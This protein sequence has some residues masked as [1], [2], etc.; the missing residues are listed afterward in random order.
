MVKSV[1]EIFNILKK[2]YKLKNFYLASGGLVDVKGVGTS[3]V[4]IVYLVSANTDYSNLD[5]IFVDYKKD[6]RPDKDRCYYISTFGGR[7]VSICAS[8]NK[9][10]MR[11]VVH[12]KAELA[13]N[14]YP[15]ITA[16]AINY[17]LDGMKTE[18]A[19]AKVLD[20][21]GDPYDAMTMN[22]TKLKKIAKEKEQKLEKI[23]KGLNTE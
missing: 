15:L 8:N 1:E 3:D 10:V 19:W 12:R 21:K 13:L 7:E 9:N 6:D 4:D 23:M 17:K 20:L 18:P 22:L 16:C 2:K 11:S 5:D 14:N